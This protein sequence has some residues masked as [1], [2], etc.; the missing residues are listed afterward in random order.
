VLGFLGGEGWID[1]AMGG[2]H[3]FA[4]EDGLVEAER[5]TGL[6]AEVKVGRGGD[7]HFEAP[8]C[9]FAGTDIARGN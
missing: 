3:D 2:D 1:L 5:L 9:W 6:I 4:A 8:A 7:G